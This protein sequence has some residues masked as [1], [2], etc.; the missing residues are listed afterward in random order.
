MKACGPPRSE[1]TC[2]AVISLRRRCRRC[3]RTT[4]LLA[5]FAACDES[6]SRRIV[7]LLQPDMSVVSLSLYWDVAPVERGNQMASENRFRA[8][9]EQILCD[10]PRTRFAKVVLGMRRGLSDVQMAHEAAASGQ[11]IRAD[12]VAAVRRIVNLTL[13]DELVTAP[14]EAEEQANMYRELLNYA[15]SPE[16]D[17][18]IST[19]LA[20]LRALGPNVR[21]TPLGAVRLGA[22]DA[23]RPTRN[24]R[25][26]PDCGL[27]HSGEC[28]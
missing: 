18:H 3:R 6:I 25:K 17:Q 4:A 28:F 16:L 11:S 21:L 7:V 12:S 20:Q 2:L 14:S 27:T 24:D 5:Q 13:N 22:N 9:M 26:C 10:H 19:R 15:R 1:P 8:E 23:P